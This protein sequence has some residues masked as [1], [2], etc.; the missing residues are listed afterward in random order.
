MK[1]IV[2]QAKWPEGFG[3]RRVRVRYFDRKISSKD[4]FMVTTQ[5][6]K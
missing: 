6:A 1:V 3:K 4:R 2:C 5:E